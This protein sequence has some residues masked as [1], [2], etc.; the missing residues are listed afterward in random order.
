[1]NADMLNVIHKYLKMFSFFLLDF[2]LASLIG[3]FHYYAFLQIAVKKKKRS[4]KQ[5]R[6]GK[7]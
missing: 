3:D 6:K 5:R 7:I 2:L 1:M 4:E